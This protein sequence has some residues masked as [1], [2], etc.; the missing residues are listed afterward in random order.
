[1][2]GPTITS[3]LA[4]AGL[5]D[6]LKVYTTDPVAF[7]T[8]L[9][10]VHGR[11]VDELR[12]D[13]TKQI[14]RKYPQRAAELSH[15]DPSSLFPA[16]AL[17]AYLKPCTS[18][19]QDSNQ[20][21]PGFGRG[22]ENM[23]RGKARNDG[24]GDLEGMAKACEKFFEW[25][26]R[27]LVTRKFTGENVGLFGAQLMNEAR[28][29]VRSVRARSPS[30]SLSSPP[31]PP[32]SSSQSSSSS[33]ITSFF[34]SAVPVASSS[35]V[36]QTSSRRSQTP[37]PHIVKI[38]S[39]RDDPTNPELREYR[40]SFKCDA[41]VDRCLAAMD[42]TRVDPKDLP[43]TER[44]VL[45]L[46]DL[47]A[48]DDDLAISSSQTQGSSAAKPDIRVWISEYLVREA[49]SELVKAY[50]E[51]LVAKATKVRTSRKAATKPRTV[52]RIK[53][54]GGENTEA[55]VDF[56]VQRPRESSPI[57][58][59]EEVEDRRPARRSNS[60]ID[61]SLSPSPRSSPTRQKSPSLPDLA[62]KLTRPALSSSLSSVGSEEPR[63]DLLMPRRVVASSSSPA[64]QARARPRT[65]AIRILSAVSSP[66]PLFVRA[67]STT[68]STATT[69]SEGHKD[70]PINLCSSDDEPSRPTASKS[71]TLRVPASS[72]AA[73]ARRKTPV[74]SKTVNRRLLRKQV[75][76]ESQIRLDLPVVAKATVWSV[77]G[78]KA[79]FI[80]D[81]VWEA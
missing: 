50:E 74:G 18:P 35:K 54:T 73:K 77:R 17:D 63:R 60:V 39:V 27:E 78:S 53:A 62:R 37:P 5:S 31:A 41:Y 14:G 43:I 79:G 16:F 81:P 15:R 80:H 28:D 46:V 11:M 52:R 20:G 13:S 26:T 61:L 24:R 51:E 69:T 21:W 59:V 8:E 7:K 64:P 4:H 36:T 44:Q 40:I 70:E 72:L 10:F 38:H 12:T 45:G 66:A 76:D 49:W 19:L 1:M 32:Q 3:A 34:A 65:K 47:V 68:S 6:F 56:F 42:G 55:F 22:M 33:R 30:L 71:H 2:P 29:R 58:E 75:N 25:G 57:E 9:S 23:K 48:T 67:L